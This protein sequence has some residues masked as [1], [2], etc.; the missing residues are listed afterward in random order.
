M[1]APCVHVPPT[2]DMRA[3]CTRLVLAQGEFA[4]RFDFSLNNGETPWRTCSRV[5]TEV[6]ASFM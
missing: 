1:T 5:G 6:L 4:G 3:I 2:I